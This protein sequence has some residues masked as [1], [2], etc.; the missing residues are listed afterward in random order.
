MRNQI[1]GKV[2][3][4]KSDKSLIVSVSRLSPTRIKGKFIKKRSKHVVHD[5]DNKAN[6]GD[7]VSIEECKPMSST[8]KW[9]LLQIKS[10]GTGDFQESGEEIGLGEENDSTSE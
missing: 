9:R 1:E 8:K 3:S 10:L 5:P 4:N 6:L 7:T 2:I